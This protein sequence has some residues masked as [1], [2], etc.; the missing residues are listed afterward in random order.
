MQD[1]SIFLVGSDGCALLMMSSKWEKVES[2]R[3]DFENVIG[4]F[5]ISCDR[6]CGF[7]MVCGRMEWNNVRIGCNHICGFEMG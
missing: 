7:E 4:N 2:I 6:I 3:S 5:K 1:K